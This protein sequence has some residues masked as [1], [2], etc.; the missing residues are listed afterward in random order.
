MFHD[1]HLFERAMKVRMDKMGST[2][3]G[4]SQ[5]I[6]ER[7][8]SGLKTIGMGLGMNGQPLTNLASGNFSKFH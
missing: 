6:P 5:G 4:S 7:L 1:Q 3:S 8:P 2:E